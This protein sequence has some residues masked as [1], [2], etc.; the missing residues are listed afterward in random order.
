MCM[1]SFTANPISLS[2]K[3]SRF[4]PSILVLSLAGIITFLPSISLSA[5]IDSSI[6]SKKPWTDDLLHPEWQVGVNRL[7]GE[8]KE[9]D[10]SATDLQASLRGTLY[11]GVESIISINAG[12]AKGKSGHFPLT[13]VQLSSKK[14]LTSDIFHPSPSFP[15]ASSI[16]V[17]VRFADKDRLKHVL[18]QERG[19]VQCQVS[20]SIGKHLAI[21]SKDRYLQGFL[22]ISY[23]ASSDRLKW[24]SGLVGLSYAFKK[25]HCLSAVLQKNWVS[26]H[27]KR[28]R[29]YTCLSKGSTAKGSLSFEYSYKLSSSSQLVLTL[30]SNLYK[31]SHWKGALK[32]STSVMLSFVKEISL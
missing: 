10:T 5:A 16:G 19:R 30:Q 31:K 29:A 22:S 12:R 15:V 8:T 2:L 1:R 9:K 7:T 3:R 21:L 27:K 6:V 28:E 20:Y 25:K 24:T 17:D 32:E 13:A 26:C 23:G 14:Q 4:T 18:F 11:P